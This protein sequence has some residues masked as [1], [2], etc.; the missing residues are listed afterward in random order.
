MW[1][2]LTGALF[3]PRFP[4]A[5][6]PHFCLLKDSTISHRR[7][8]WEFR[9]F[10][11]SREIQQDLHFPCTYL[12]SNGLRSLKLENTKIK[13]KLRA[14]DIYYAGQWREMQKALKISR[15][16]QQRGPQ[17]NCCLNSLTEQLGVS[18]SATHSQH[19]PIWVGL[20]HAEDLS[21]WL[22]L[23][24][25]FRVPSLMWLPGPRFS[26][27]ADHALFTH[28]NSKNSLLNGFSPPWSQ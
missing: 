1:N 17:W 2:I 24:K 15:L 22:L 5:P 16:L 25:L 8:K 23:T 14:C 11:P 7:K 13:I 28:Q 27:G 6:P 3:S 18:K 20:L 9:I 19:L 21:N 26:K 10:S 4:S 12:L